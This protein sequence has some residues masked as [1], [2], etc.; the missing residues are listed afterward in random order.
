MPAALIGLNHWG[1]VDEYFT[2][3]IWPSTESP[4]PH[5]SSAGLR[6][7]LIEI[8]SFIANGQ[9]VML[10]TFSEHLHLASTIQSLAEQTLRELGGFLG[11]DR[12]F[13]VEPAV[14]VEE[15]RPLQNGEWHLSQDPQAVAE[16][17]SRRS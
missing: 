17:A 12:P 8:T 6:P 10:W 4:G 13:V 3:L 2:E 11:A 1:Q 16:R 7:R 9:L 15:T 5:R 14:L